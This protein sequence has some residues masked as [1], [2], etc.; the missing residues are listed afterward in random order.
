MEC[1]RC[2][3]P[4][5]TGQRFCGEC[6]AALP[7]PQT[8]ARE[9]R[10][11]TVLFADVVGFTALSEQLDPEVV[12]EIMDGCFG[13]LAREVGRY[14]GRV[15][16]FTG[17]GVMALFGAPLAEEDHAIR[18]VLAALAIQEGL[19]VYGDEIKRRHGVDF[20]LRLGV[21]TGLVLAGGMGDGESVEYTALGDTINLAARL[22]SSA[23][24]GGVLVGEATRRAAGEAFQWAE[25]GPLELKGKAEPV[26]AWEPVGVDD[27][28]NRFELLAKRGL[29][30]FV[31]RNRELE[32]L[33]AAWQRAAGGR[34]QVVSIV[35]EAGL[36]KSRLLHEFKTELARRAVPLSEGSCFTY[37]EAT[38][39]LPFL[40]VAR[41][42]L[43]T[44]TADQTPASPYLRLLLGLDVDDE[45]LTRQSP[46]AIRQHTIEAIRDLILA[47]A[48]AEPMVLVVEDVHWIDKASEDVLSAVVE[49]MADVGLLLVLLYRPEYLHAWSEV[50][51]H[52]E[53]SLDRLGGAS[54]AAMVR[55][56]L[57]KS[58]AASVTLDRL[59]A[60]DTRSMVRQLLGTATIPPELEQLVATSTDGNPLFIEELTRDLIESG[61]LVHGDSGYTLTRPPEALTLPTTVQGV[62]LARV[63]R[64]NPN[65]RG[66]LQVASVLGRVF[67]YRLLGAVANLDEGLDS[68]LLQL[69]D[70]D[71]VH[72]SA[73][74]PERQYSFKHVL[75]QEAVYQTLTK[76]QREA[77]HERAGQAVETL[78]GDRLDEWVE[79]LA[80]HYT[81]SGNDAKALE[82]L[83]WANRKAARAHALAEAKGFFDEA[84]SLLDRIPDTPD[85]RHRRVLL[86]TEQFRTY[87]FLFLI[88]EY[89]ELAR[90]YE[91]MAIEV[92]DRPLLGMLYK[93]IA[94]CQFFFGQWDET[95]RFAHRAATLFEAAGDSAGM[96]M[97]CELVQW[98]HLVRG[99]LEDSQ[100][101]ADKALAAFAESLDVTYCVWTHSGLAWAHAHAGRW[102]EALEACR[103]ALALAEEYGDE[104]LASFSF[105][106]QS[107]VLTYQGDID[108]A[109]RSAQEAL[110]RA[111]G[112]AEE[113]WARCQ[114]AWAECRAGKAE[115]S[116]EVLSALAPLLVGAPVVLMDVANATYLG[117]A[118]W[119]AGRLVEATET[120]RAVAKRAGDF[121]MFFYAGTAHRLL[122][123]V[124]GAA[125]EFEQSIAVLSQIGAEN[126][127]ALAYAGYSRLLTE[128]G[129]EE[130]GRRYLD[131][132]R[133]TFS[134]LGTTV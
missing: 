124:T 69:E 111:S 23:R 81:R 21:N 35:G 56:I 3:A 104:A 106:M 52:A 54:S 78:Y 18:A 103:P 61:H 72:Q 90:S 63:D 77:Q 13:L 128:A 132:A 127:L 33:V 108:G 100:A 102:R 26:A 86:V 11:V 79:L 134:R 84:M 25:V 133:E 28:Q 46:A 99:E 36:G 125:D 97:A 116:I 68:A 101:W 8:A 7:A 17:D 75:A 60:E 126:E 105:F 29:T 98:T 38:S 51:Y 89:V 91:A 55:A 34:G 64:L 120:L 121:G 131:A 49:A 117:E 39:Y 113:A 4:N 19:P 85:N 24:P 32:S 9:R 74:A 87:F 47:R 57:S 80:R 114:L 42:L 59:S 71:L 1:L 6:G 129:H 94:H 107:I 20:Q 67:T 66:L 112:P 83:A 73:L 130:E 76:A 53:V 30:S 65:L 123:E 109:C 45:L 50:A 31:G 119:R 15:N 5:R 58:Y 62:L 110:E 22:E 37:G 44:D 12:H 82:Y 70:L 88:R 10:Q 118:Y 92:D 115:G 48:S 93:N 14:G 95:L 16:A 43:G 41:G 96:G 27:N 40:E 2:Q 122:G